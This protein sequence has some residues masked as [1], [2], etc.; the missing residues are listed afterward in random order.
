MGSYLEQK[1]YNEGYYEGKAKEPRAAIC[2][3]DNVDEYLDLCDDC[4]AP[5][6]LP[7]PTL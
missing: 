3:H 5:V 1:E 4:G 7:E 2:E 6:K